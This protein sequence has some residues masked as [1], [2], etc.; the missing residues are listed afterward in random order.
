MP[1]AKLEITVPDSVWIG[2]LSRN[3]PEAQFEILTVFPKD[4]GGVALTEI[5][6]D[7]VEEI[8]V[9][10]DGYDEVT[11]TDYLQRTDDTALVQFET[12]NPVLL[13]PV[14]NAGTPLEL[15]FTVVDGSVTWEVTAPRDRLS[16]LGDQLRQFGIDF[17]V[18][19]VRQEMETEQLLTPKQ[20]RLVRTAVEQGYYDTPRECTLTELAEEADIAKSTCS[21]TLH[22]A[23]EKIVKEFTDDVDL[24]EDRTPAVRA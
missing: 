11:S 9:E 6:G 4:E 12:S 19:A 24:S 15:P 16:S 23:E 8:V 20:L 5:T 18:L 22:R 21:E 1:R 10:M 13:L 14:R 17:E 2:E 7:G 3:H